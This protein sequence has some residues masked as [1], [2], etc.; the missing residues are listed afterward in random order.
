MSIG[1]AVKSLL[2]TQEWVFRENIDKEHGGCWDRAAAK[3]AVRLHVGRCSV[4]GL[5]RCHSGIYTEP[6]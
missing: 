5:P 3:A 4:Q 1:S 2:G 6:R